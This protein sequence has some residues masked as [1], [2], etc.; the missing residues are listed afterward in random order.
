MSERILMK[1][2]IALA[3]GAI[4]AGCTHYF[5]YPI[6]PQNEIPE[7]MSGEMKKTGKTYLQA[8]SEVA[9]INMLFGAAAAGTRAMT[10]TSSPGY[11][12]MQ[13]GVSYIAGAH[14]PC[15]IANVQRGGPG[16]GNIATAQADYFQATKGGGHGD[17]RLIVIAPSSPQEMMDY[18]LLAFDLADEYRIPV[19]LLSDATIGQMM[20]AVTIRSDYLPKTFPKQWALTGCAGRNPNV[21]R[22]LWLDETG[23]EKNNFKL[24]EKYETIVKKEVRFEEFQIDDASIVLIAYG[25]SSRIC[26]AIVLRAR[27]EGMKIGLLRPITLWPFPYERIAAFANGCVKLLLVVEM[28][29]GQMIEDVR[30]GIEGKIPVEFYG[31]MGGRVPSDE[32]IY[33]KVKH[34]YRE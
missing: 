20:E 24:Q 25:L 33:K 31:T 11:S 15:V 34:L 13:E 29:A 18:T 17:Y 10:T 32:E 3:K 14:L 23:V 22:T 26:R 7:F 27:S 5:G 1:G 12:L 21:V 8:E 30:L 9:A 19:L 28:S 4:I 2:N 16:L 6:T